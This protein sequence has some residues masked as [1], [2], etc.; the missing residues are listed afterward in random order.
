M[1]LLPSV[2]I[3]PFVFPVQEVENLFEG[4]TKYS[5]TIDY[6]KCVISIEKDRDI[7]MQVQ[8]LLHE[9]V[10]GIVM[11]NQ[12]KMSEETVDLVAMSL[13]DLIPQLAKMWYP[14]LGNP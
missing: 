9:V 1:Q 7:Q 8:T 3:G 12:I 14:D 6:S 5:G 2:K 13:M 4:S 10:H 11:V